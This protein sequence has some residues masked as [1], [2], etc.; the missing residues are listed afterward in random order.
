M[1]GLDVRHVLEMAVRPA[2][3]VLGPQYATVA[4][5]QL[6][7]GTAVKESNLIWLRQLGTGPAVGLWQ[8]EPFTFRDIRDNFLSGTSTGKCALRRALASFSARM[9]HEPDELAWNL[10]LGAAY[11]RVRYMYAMHTVNGVRVPEPLPAAWDVK[12]M[13]SY[14]KR[15]YNTRLGK[16][17]PEEFEH[18]WATTIAPV[19]DKL[20]PK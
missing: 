8:M 1:S 16:G 9:R 20:W 5:E 14:W 15:H 12:A 11:C 4:A 18:A 19:A 7:L 10:R 13:A 2:L 6:V 3:E 17:K